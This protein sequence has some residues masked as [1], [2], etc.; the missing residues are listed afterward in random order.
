MILRAL[1]EAV[2]ILGAMAFGF[3]LLIVKGMV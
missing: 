3:Q 2:A 1:I